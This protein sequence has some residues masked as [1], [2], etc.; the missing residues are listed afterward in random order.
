MRSTDR[1]NA[2]NELVSAWEAALGPQ[3]TALH[4]RIR[5]YVRA[6]PLGSV[7]RGQGVFTEAGCSSPVLRPAFRLAAVFGLA[8]PERGMSIPFTIEN[9][10]DAHGVIHARRELRF[11]GRVRVMVDAIR[12]HRGFA[13]DAL[14]AGGP[15]EAALRVSVVDGALVARSG[16]VRVRVGTR[17]WR[18]PHAVRPHVELTERWDDTVGRQHVD[19]AVTLPG[20]GRIYGYWGWFDYDISP[21]QNQ[22]HESGA[23]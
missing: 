6:V 17:W 2:R 13:V 19:V 8:F 21:E 18:L 11:P 7:G 12:E 9:R 15:C 20:F 10:A 23:R 3:L 14:G 1:V 16:A 22:H 5:E 4:P